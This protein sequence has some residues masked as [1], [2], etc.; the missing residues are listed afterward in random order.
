MGYIEKQIGRAALLEQIAEEASELAKA[1]LKEARVIRGENPTPVTLD[2][3]HNYVIEEYTD[4]IQCSRELDLK[5][6]DEQ[7]HKK[8]IRWHE[9][10][11]KSRK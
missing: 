7:I 3:A 4:V 5:I 6:D 8:D 10:I 2:E 9:R 1:A 11:N